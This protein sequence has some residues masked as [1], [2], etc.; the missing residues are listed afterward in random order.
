MEISEDS[1]SVLP[2]NYPIFLKD[3]DGSEDTV[4]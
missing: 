4:E 1:N 3:T 2:Q